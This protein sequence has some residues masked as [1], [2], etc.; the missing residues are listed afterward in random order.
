MHL[1]TTVNSAHSVVTVCFQTVNALM[2]DILMVIFVYI[3]HGIQKVNTEIVLVK[4]I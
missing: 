3:V 1:Q 2:K 4:K